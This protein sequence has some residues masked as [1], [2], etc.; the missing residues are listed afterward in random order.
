MVRMG[1][2]GFAFVVVACA[3]AVVGYASTKASPL[4]P[5]SHL[6]SSKLSKYFDVGQ[7]KFQGVTPHSDICTWLGAR[8]GHYHAQLQIGFSPGSKSLFQAVTKSAETSAKRRG[9]TFSTVQKSSPA[10]IEVSEIDHGGS[11]KPCGPGHTIPEFGPPQCESDPAWY[12]DSA[13]AD[14]RMKRGGASVIVSAN[15]GAELGDVGVHEMVKL[16]KD[17]LSGRV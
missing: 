8:T 1:V 15:A 7:L 10:I 17:I 13:D 4:P 14:G 11:L 9:A 16:C 6:S 12:T 5:C 2:A 3:T